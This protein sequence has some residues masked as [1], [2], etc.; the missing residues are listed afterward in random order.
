MA[1][2]SNIP[3]GFILGHSLSD[4]SIDPQNPAVEEFRLSHSSGHRGHRN[5]DD[6]DEEDIQYTNKSPLPRSG[7]APRQSTRR[8]FVSGYGL[9]DDT[10]EEESD[11]DLPLAAKAKATAREEPAIKSE[12]SS[13]V[14]LLTGRLDPWDMQKLTL[15]EESRVRRAQDCGREEIEWV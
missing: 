10:S 6:S 3:L 2:V 8:P 1:P 11:S 14:S 9:A 4:G 12:F 15:Q 7:H 5:I 13:Y